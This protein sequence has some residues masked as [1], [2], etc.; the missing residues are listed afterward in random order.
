MDKICL[1]CGSREVVDYHQD[2]RRE[3]FQC[4]VC[5]LVFVPPQAH[6]SLADEKARY[7][8]HTNSPDDMGYRDFLGNLLHPMIERLAPGASGIDFGCGPGPTLSLMFEEAGFSCA[9]YDPFF[10]PDSAV[11]DRAYDFLSCSEVIEHCGAPMKEFE[12]FRT[13]VKPGGLIGVMTQLVRNREMFAD[14]FYIDDPT[15]ICFFSEA[16]FFWLAEKLGMRV[17]FYK[18]SVTLFWV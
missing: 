9:N 3:Y 17:E 10:A 15:H 11:L 12:L 6:L 7:A 4:K 5:A 1:L 2:R 13:L 8:L 16:T 14:W 18:K